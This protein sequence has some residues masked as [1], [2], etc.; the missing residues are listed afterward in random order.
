M[1]DKRLILVGSGAPN[2]MKSTRKPVPYTTQTV[3]IDEVS[4]KIVD[5]ALARDEATAEAEA[6]IRALA[7]DQERT[8]AEA[9]ERAEAE[10]HKLAQPS[11]LTDEEESQRWNAYFS[12]QNALKREKQQ[13]QEEREKQEQA[14][15]DA[16]KL[17]L[18]D[19]MFDSYHIAHPTPVAP[20]AHVAQVTP[21][22]PVKQPRT[23]HFNVCI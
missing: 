15:E 18:I 14:T 19:K 12:A 13:A 3:P 21:D 4:R 9:Q 2:L 16:R 1:E 23:R 5:D 11:P 17:A 7:D 8:L 10:A 22:T 20:V 6:H